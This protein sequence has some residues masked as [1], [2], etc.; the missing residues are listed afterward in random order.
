M[1]RDAVRRPAV[2]E[3]R[4]CAGRCGLNPDQL[5]IRAFQRERPS[6]L[7]ITSTPLTAALGAALLEAGP[8]RTRIAFAPAAMFLQA[9]GAVQGG[10]VGAMLDFGM[11]YAALDSVADGL[12][13]ATASTSTSFLRSLEAGPCE[14]V[15]ILERRGA[16]LVFARAR[17]VD[18]S[19]RLAATATSVLSI[20]APRV[21]GRP[22]AN[23]SL[24]GPASMV[25]GPGG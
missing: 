21:G 2:D 18:G 10:I 5:L 19:D 3:R 17:I 6:R 15:A 1:P 9:E 23:G 20:V 25:A 7:P 22:S 4:A 14:V 8:D 11:A 13:V 24:S 16:Q 12:S